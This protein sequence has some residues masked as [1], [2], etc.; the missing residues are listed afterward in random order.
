[1]PQQTL[2]LVVALITAFLIPSCSH[3]SQTG[4][5]PS[6]PSRLRVGLT[7]H[8]PPL[9][10]G[11]ETGIDGLEPAL[12]RQMGQAL[13]RRVEFVVLEPTER[14]PALER[15]DVDVLM[16]HWGSA[17]P[18]TESILLTRPY[19][20]GG[21]RAAIRKADLR[22]LGPPGGIHL[23][24]VRIGYTRHRPGEDYARKH[25][26]GEEVQVYAFDSTRAALRSLR[27]DRIDFLIGEVPGLGWLIEESQDTGII[28]LETPLTEEDFS[29]AVSKNNPALASDLDRVQDEWRVSD[30]LRRTLD[31]WIPAS[32]PIP[33]P[34]S[35]RQSTSVGRSYSR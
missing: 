25:L 24:G 18:G 14:M 12:A 1:M 34:S 7:L 13:G 26:D 3:M 29:W 15:G 9:A 20:R 6:D 28:T 2:T 19:L 30:A 31:Q 32:R 10:F 23:S 11:S 16:G 5:A 21:L 22:R 8:R 17:S 27:A 35:G 33:S 4:S